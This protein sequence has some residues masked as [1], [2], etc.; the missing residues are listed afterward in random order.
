[1]VPVLGH[2]FWSE[3]T[4]LSVMYGELI[5]FSTLGFLL[6]ESPRETPSTAFL[7]GGEQLRAERQKPAREA[8][9]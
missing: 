5:A 9:R 8:G 2:F 4:G 3:P 6:G 7:H 1:M